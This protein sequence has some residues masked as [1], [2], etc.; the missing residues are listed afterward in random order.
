MTTTMTKD[1][2]IV[3]REQLRENINGI[4][5]EIRRIKELEKPYVAA[6]SATNGGGE[7]RFKTEKLA[8]KKFEEYAKKDIY[9]GGASHGAFLFKYNDD[10]TKTLLDVQPIGKDDFYPYQFD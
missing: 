1:Q 6:I 10:G 7:T 4:N 3:K 2:L 5:R 9:R 8:R